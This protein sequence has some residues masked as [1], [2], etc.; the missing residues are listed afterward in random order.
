MPTFPPVTDTRPP[1]LYTVL[2]LLPRNLISVVVGWI[3]RLRLPTPLARPLITSF[4]KF[5][6]IDVSEAEMSLDSYSTIE[7]VFTRRLRPGLR[8]I[9]GALV[10]PADGM[11]TYSAPVTNGTALQVKGFAYP[12]SELVYG[13]E[14]VPRSEL[15]AAWAM[16]FYLAPHNYHRVHVPISGT[17]EHVR[18]IPGDLWPVNETFVRLVPS[19]FTKN[20]RLV[21]RIRI[22][23]GGYVDAV[24]VGAFNVGRMTTPFLPDFASNTFR[25]GRPMRVAID[26]PIAVGDE[27]GTFML[28]S[29]VVLIFSDEACRRFRP[30]EV[31]EKRPSR[32]GERLTVAPGES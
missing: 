12:V 9:D 26:K 16:T 4:V 31:H 3:V 25:R 8:P 29:T 11:W 13:S 17:L 19:L 30:I 15:Q 18:Y 32:M 24:M 22:T 28:G 5:F 10:A 7:D 27:L 14:P 21:F 6:G 20:E 23:G 2:S 1:A